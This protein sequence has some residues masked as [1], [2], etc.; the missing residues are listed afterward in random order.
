MK[1][2]ESEYYT[3]KKN[4]LYC[5]N[6]N[7]RNIA[8][9]VGTPVYVYSKKF[10]ED[11]YHEYSNAFK[12]INNKIFYAS[13]A[14]F[15]LSI[16]SLLND[17]GAVIDVNSAGEF[18]R[19]KKAGVDPQ[20]MI[21]S[22]VGKSEEEIQIAIKNNIKLIKSESLDEIKLV[23]GIAGKLNKKAPVA[24]RV[25]PNVDPSTHPYI[26][27]GLAENKFGIDESNA[28]EIFN[29]AGQMQNISLVGID[30]HIGS[31]ITTIDPYKEAI[32]KII[33]LVEEIKK[34]GIGLS[35]IDIG[36]GMGIK[37]DN[38]NVFSI[39]SFADIIIPLL[40]KTDCE[41]YIEPGRSLLANSGSLVSKVLYSK[42]N[43]DKNFLVVDAAMNDL[44][45]PSIYS[46]YHH[47]QPLQKGMYED[48]IADIVGPVCES[49]DFLGK[50]RTIENCRGGDFIAV[51]SAGAYGM[52]MSSNYNARCRP[53]EILVDGDDYRI[54]RKR[55][56]YDQL[57][58]N[59]INL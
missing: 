16:I 41:V 25:N 13:K 58:L 5:E 27:T 18:Y 20:N 43:L 21:F 45:R 34:L 40:A 28:I 3:Y 59:E 17:L 30:M 24:I 1:L 10:I 49:G 29:K 14:N 11:R 31:Q 36:G 38:E 52:V 50:N 57:V 39:K 55:E 47:I 46:A 6:V 2:F 4:Q 26:S 51:M 19:A 32:E 56:T 33:R 53:A 7:L 9:N 35:H 8:E 23:D 54:I 15:N 44:L 42:K 12:D 37:Y 48:I 22:G